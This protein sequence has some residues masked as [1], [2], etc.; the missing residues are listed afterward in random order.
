MFTTI[1]QTPNTIQIQYWLIVS[2]FIPLACTLSCPG[3]EPAQPV[4]FEQSQVIATWDKYKGVLTFGRNQ[5]LALLDDGCD[6]SKPEWSADANSKY[7]K[8][9]VTYDSVDGD[10][11]P[12]HEGRGYHGT[13]IG[14]PS[15]VNHNGKRGVAFN[16]QLAIIRSLECCHCKIADSKTLASALK[17][18][19]DNYKKHRITTVNLAPVDDLAHA[20]PVMTEIDAQLSRLRTLG[21]WVSAPTGNHN[22]T[23]GISWPASQPKCFAIGAVTPGRNVVFLDRHQKVDLVV[24]AH[25]TSSSNA[26]LC[27]S[28]MILRE[29]ISKSKY[30]WSQHGDNLP[31]AMMAIFKQT[32]TPLKDSGTGLTFH[33]LNLLAAVDFVFRKSNEP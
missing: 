15:S 1:G 22:Y 6:L 26:I 31:E 23:T 7:P 16:N 3:A 9:L 12:K 21:I 20:K 29:A 2:L 10:A 27:G 33:Q 5:T 13:T 18:V 28:A 4:P 25:A 24:P 19:A 17:W 11:D 32:G 8:V 30:D 14:I